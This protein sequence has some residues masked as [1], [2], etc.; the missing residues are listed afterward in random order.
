MAHSINEKCIGCG[1]CSRVCPI[2]AISGG[3]KEKHRI[4]ASVCIDCGA[5]GTVCMKEAVLDKNGEVCVKIPDSEK[6]R[7]YVEREKCTAC[8]LCVENCVRHALSIS[9]PSFKGDIAL[10]SVLVNEKACTGCGMCFRV[11][12]QRAITMTAGGKNN[13]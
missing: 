5:C 10:Y 11:C 8:Q 13:E 2:G 12:P 6:L 7:P 9:E 3:L 1:M 4:D